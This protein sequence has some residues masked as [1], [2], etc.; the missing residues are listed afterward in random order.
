MRKHLFFL[1]AALA[2]SCSGKKEPGAPKV[3]EPEVIYEANLI[4]PLYL[5]YLFESPNAFGPAWDVE[6]CRKMKFEKISLYVKGGYLPNHMSE[7]FTYTFDTDGNPRDY[8]YYIYTSSTDPFS[9][10]RFL[11]DEKGKLAKVDISKYLN[12]TNL[13]PLVIKSD[14]IR[15]IAIASKGAGQSDSLLFYPSI[16]KPKMIVE[17]V[18]SFI[19]SIEIFVDKNTNNSELKN[20]AMQVD[21]NLVD[22]D[23][24]EKTVTYMENGLPIESYHLDKSWNKQEK[25][26]QWDYNSKNQPVKYKEWLHGTQIKDIVIN[27]RDNN[28]PSEII[29]DRKKYIFYAALQ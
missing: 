19:N 23:L 25:S 24:T 22:F 16:E 2:V 18:N 21:S 27:Y 7:K 28:L 4:Q 6:A 29:V 13:P 11:Y 12:F 14:S 1:V 17:V 9:N 10:S 5:G 3:K 15:T 8:A 26:R 20:I